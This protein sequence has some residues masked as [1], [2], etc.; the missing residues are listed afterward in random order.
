[1]LEADAPRRLVAFGAKKGRDL[2][3]DALR[4]LACRHAQGFPNGAQ[5]AGGRWR[6]NIDPCQGVDD[7]GQLIE[8]KLSG[9]H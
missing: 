1:M 6:G 2:D 3:A 9:A 4:K 7:A 5:P 8:V